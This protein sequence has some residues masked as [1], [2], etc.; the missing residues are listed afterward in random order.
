MAWYDEAVFYHIYPLGL[1]GA[2]KQNSYGEPVHRLN[3]LLP[4]ISHIKE[5]GCNA[6]YIGPLFE[7]VGHG[8]ETTDYKKLDSRLGT[9]EDLTNFVAECHKQGIRVILDGVFNHTGRDFFAF[10][11][12]KYNRENS[13]YKDWYC[14]VNF[15]GNNSFNDGFSYENWGGYDL[16]AKLNQ[17]NPAVKDYICDVIRFWVSEF[18]IDGIRLD[19]AD[20]LDFEYMKELRHVANEVKP[21]FWLMGE[22][23]HGNYSRWAN[24]GTLH[25]VTNYM[26]HKALYSAHNDHN[27]FEVAHTIKYVGEMVGN[28][29][30]LY[31]FVDN[32]DV[33]RIYTKLTNKAHFVPVHVMLYTLPGIPSLYYGSEFGIEGRKER[34]SDDSLRPALNYE[35]YKDAVEKNPCTKLIAALGKIR[36]NTPALCY[37]DYKELELQTTHYAY[38]RVLDGKSV[39]TTVNNADNDVSMNLPAGN[40]AEYVGALTGQKV[41]VNGGRI[42][43]NVPANFGEIWIPAELC[44]ESFAPIKT[45]EIKKS[46]VQVKKVEEPKPEPVKAVEIP[47]QEAPKPVKEVKTEPVK[48]AVQ[49]K[50]EEPKKEEVKKAESGKV[51]VDWNKRYEDMSVEELQE[52]ILEKMRKN[53][54]VTDYMLGTVRENTHHGSLVTWVRSFC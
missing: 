54:P 34:F 35:D 31:S 24:D 11:D 30:K 22:V 52:A 4:W 45:V 1:T 2:S 20:V 27:Y 12:I 6:I 44:G 10:Q 26:L 48:T 17:H 29:L 3:T 25:S 33:E 19:A 16:L 37:G 53:G 50:V 28:N 41:A 32:H 38:A 9:N 15:W 36:Q 43:V 23:I 14:N 21:D 40:S 8:Y 47:K 5:I 39:I 46:P 7:S 42:S 49:P 51:V 18:D 13:Q